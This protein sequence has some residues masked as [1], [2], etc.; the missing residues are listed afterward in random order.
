MTP[1]PN[2]QTDLAVPEAEKPSQIITLAKG[3]LRPMDKSVSCEQTLSREDKW[4]TYLEGL[5]KQPP[6]DLEWLPY[7]D[8]G[9]RVLWNEVEAVYYLL[10]HKEK[11]ERRKGHKGQAIYMV[12][13]L[14]DPLLRFLVK[15]IIP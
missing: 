7:W 5:R 6:N 12:G 15:Q 3:K 13:A 9:W 4:E 10:Y 11:R 8:T 1:A 14:C 2:S